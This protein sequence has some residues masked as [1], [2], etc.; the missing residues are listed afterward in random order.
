[1]L[2]GGIDLS[3]GAVASMA[4]FVTATLINSSGLPVAIIVPL[5][6]RPSSALITGIGVGVFGSTR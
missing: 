4:G 3:V 1:M 6:S 5:W 2:T